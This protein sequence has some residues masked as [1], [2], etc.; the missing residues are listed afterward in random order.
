MNSNALVAGRNLLQRRLDLKVLRR[1][2]NAWECYL[3][4]VLDE[5][6][7]TLVYHTVAIVVNVSCRK[8][9]SG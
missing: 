4:L 9:F 2:F 1:A 5:I 8:S 7:E 6:H 3:L